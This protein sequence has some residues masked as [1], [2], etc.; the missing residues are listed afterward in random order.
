MALHEKYGPL[1]R[2]APNELSYSKPDGVPVIYRLSNPL[3][4]TDWY[5][6]WKGAGLKSQIDMFTITNEKRHTAY[7]RV[8][9]AVYSLTSILKNEAQIDQNVNMLI[10]RLDGFVKRKEEVDLGLWV[11]MYAYDNIG[12]V[13]FGQPF[14]FL[15]TSSDH[16]GYIAAVHA[17]MPFLSVIC[18]TPTYARTLLMIA[19]A[20]VP[21][22]LRAVLAVDNIRKTAVRETEKAM[23]RKYDVQ[24]HDTVTRLLQTIEKAGEKHGITHHEVTGEMWVAVM[25]GADSTAG[26]LRAILYN[27]LKSPSTMA[28][29][30]A[31]IDAAYA[32]GSLASPA[33]HSQVTKLPYLMAVCREAARIWPSFQVTMPRYAPAGGLQLPNGFCV[34]A[35]YRVGINPYIVQRDLE[36]FG[37]DANVFRPERWLEADKERLR[38]MNTT[39]LSFGAG[40]RTCTGQHLAMAEIYKIVPEL[41]HR[42]KIDMPQEREW[43]AFNASFSLTTGLV[44]ELERRGV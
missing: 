42:F 14:G 44:C 35:G 37:N 16:G 23:A 10:E 6:V 21:S 8:V 28:R 32:D 41:L 4:K 9:G 12:S 2:I 33:Q 38:V 30:T 7:R 27:L 29:L 1:I 5:H 26:T 19:A 43:S 24:R 17:A 3:E 39:M 18:M 31:E 11:E 36:L 25:A 15:E 22:L 20:A 13:S 34:P 40:T